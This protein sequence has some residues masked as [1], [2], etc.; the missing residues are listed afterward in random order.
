MQPT[1]E[2]TN[3]ILR[4]EGTK[5][6]AY[7]DSKRFW[8]IGTGHKIKDT[9]I[10]HA[11]D[12]GEELTISP[13]FAAALLNYDLRTAVKE[14][15]RIFPDLPRYL[16]AR[17]TALVSIVFQLGAID[18]FGPNFFERLI[19]R[20]HVGNWPDAGAELLWRDGSLKRQPTQVAIDTPARTSQTA[21]MLASGQF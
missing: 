14:A 19:D 6:A 3:F 12:D 9:A 10:L 21:E 8:T 17:Q 7:R 11:L 1:P 20:V 13:N 4:Q 16:P 18:A 2:T 5:L 15:L